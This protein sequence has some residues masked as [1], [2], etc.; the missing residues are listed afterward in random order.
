[1]IKQI[2][3]DIQTRLEAIK[4]AENNFILT[5]FDLWNQQV[6]FIEEETPFNT[7]AAF[8]EILPIQWQQL[9]G[10]YQQAEV[11]IRLHL[12]TQ[13]FA[14]T[15]K[16]NPKQSAAL[17]YLDLPGKVFDAMHKFS[18][19]N[20]NQFVRVRSVVNHNHERYVD[21]VEEYTGL[22]QVQAIQGNYTEVNAKPK[23][24][25]QETE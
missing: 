3:T 12:V 10:G 17:D 1:M 16:Y 23:I 7:P 4:D 24:T 5:H 11:T 14:Q 13:W 18:I 6:N 21:S 25:E 9:S 2:Y 19:A 20:S 8:V 15:A 22:V